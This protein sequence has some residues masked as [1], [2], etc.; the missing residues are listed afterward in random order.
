MNIQKMGGDDAHALAY[1]GQSQQPQVMALPEVAAPRSNP[2][3]MIWRRKGVL[4]AIMAVCVLAAM[5]VYWFSPQI[6]RSEARLF[7]HTNAPEGATGQNS[8]A[9]QCELIKSASILANVLATE[10]VANSRTLKESSSRWKTLKENLNASGTKDNDIITVSYESPYPKE[11]QTILKAVVDAY[12]VYHNK[13]KVSRV[14]ELEKW[15]DKAK[16]ELTQKQKE[17]LDF[18]KANAALAMTGEKGNMT[19]QKLTSLQEALTAAHIDTVNARSAYDSV[20]L[21]LKNATQLHALVEYLRSTGG[22]G[23]ND[24]NEQALR[25]QLM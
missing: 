11:A 20:N 5:A 15:R 13:E 19:I 3:L 24:S 16:E 17:L 8:L 1:T 25:S 23:N 12:S 7:V 22:V 14:F 10:E 9:A 21:K 18:K 2:L 6:F 4:L